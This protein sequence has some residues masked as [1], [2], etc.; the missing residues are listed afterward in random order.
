MTKGVIFHGFFNY[1]PL[2]Y[3]LIIAKSAFRVLMA[4]Y[5]LI[6]NDRS[7]IDLL[8]YSRVSLFHFKD[9]IGKVLSWKP[10]RKK[11]KNAR[12]KL[13]NIYTSI[14]LCYKTVKFNE[15]PGKAG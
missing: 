9:L 14:D 4:I 3:R 7:W 5:H 11:S 2:A 1:S 12:T 6:C 8:L 13:A 10:R 15:K